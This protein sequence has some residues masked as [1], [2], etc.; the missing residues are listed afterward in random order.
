MADTRWEVRYRGQFLGLVPDQATATA[1]QTALAGQVTDALNIAIAAR[2]EID[3]LCNGNLVDSF[4]TLPAAQAAAAAIVAAV[5]PSPL[6]PRAAPPPLAAYAFTTSAQR[7]APGA[8]LAA[9][10]PPLVRAAVAAKAERGQAVTAEA[11]PAGEPE[12]GEP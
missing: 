7:A 10:V 5:P 6:P 3:M 4:D 8:I 9:E 12:R 11:W 2:R 1:F